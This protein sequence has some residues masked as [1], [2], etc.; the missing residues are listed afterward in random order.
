MNSGSITFAL[1]SCC[2]HNSTLCFD[3]EPGFRSRVVVH[4]DLRPDPPSIRIPLPVFHHRDRGIGSHWRE[5]P[6]S[7]RGRCLPTQTR[8]HRPQCTPLTWRQYRMLDTSSKDL[9]TPVGTWNR[10]E[11]HPRRHC[12]PDED[13]SS[14]GRSSLSRGHGDYC[15]GLG[16]HLGA[17]RSRGHLGWSSRSLNNPRS[18]ESK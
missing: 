11:G 18:A 10:E 6:R 12:N 8:W 3:S 2:C 17:R 15:D 14:D 16:H 7:L 5:N 4:L 13:T 9:M 1:R